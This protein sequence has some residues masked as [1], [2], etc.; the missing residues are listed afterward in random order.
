MTVWCKTA[1]LVRCA[2]TLGAV[3]CAL[4]SGMNRADEP[5]ELEEPNSSSTLEDDAQDLLFLGPMRPVLI[6]LHVQVNRQPFRQVWRKNVEKL[7]RGADANHDGA[8]DLADPQPPAKAA[9]IDALAQKAAAYLG[10]DAEAA[11]S[12]LRQLASEHDGRLSESALVEYFTR[13][14]PPLAI[15][16][17]NGPLRYAGAGMA[18]APAL[19]PLLDLD[20]DQQLTAE[21]LSAAEPR[22][23]NRDFNEDEVLSPRELTAAPDASLAAAAPEASERKSILPGVASLFLIGPDT[24]PESIAAAIVERYDH[25]RDGKLEAAADGREIAF[26][27]D[28]VRKFDRDGDGRLNADELLAFARGGPGV[29][30]TTMLGKGLYVSPSQRKKLVQVHAAAGGEVEAKLSRNGAFKLTFSDASLDLHLSQSD[31]AQ[32]ADD[33]PNLQNFDADNNGYLDAGEL[34]GNAELAAAF[35]SIDADGDGKIF[36]GEFNAYHQRQ[37]RAASSR[38]LLEVAD[39]GQQLLHVLDADPDSVLSV[40]E[41]R[42]AAAALDKADA[43]GDGRL[44]G[45]EIPQRLAVELSRNTP[46]GAQAAA[47]RPMTDEAERREA[48]A[49]PAWFRKLDRNR[50]GDLSRREFVGPAEIFERLDL[51]GDGLLSAAEADQA[52]P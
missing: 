52:T 6:R 25:D 12:A 30:L 47:A 1:A 17:N 31:P 10:Q 48:A 2:A 26:P 21:E 13:V 20:G 15:V 24:P 41:L 33:G 29:E 42:G 49:G 34:A 51:D 4:T 43:N 36:G 45:N 5:G 35:E 14:A 50:D 32:T 3:C 16:A 27:A 39:G 44:A 38:L 46:A 19:F 7:F 37:A 18:P 9:E 28:Q 8:I 22:L 40:R 23:A 11:K